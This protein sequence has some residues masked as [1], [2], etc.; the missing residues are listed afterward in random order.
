MAD[1]KSQPEPSMEEI[2]ASIRRI[3]SEEEQPEAQVAKTAT[4]APAAAPVQ[5][6]APKPAPAAA[7]AP[8]PEPADDEV[9]DLTD[10]VAEDGTVVNLHAEG[11]ATRRAKPEPAPQPSAQA[12]D[13]ELRDVGQNGGDEPPRLVPQ[14]PHERRPSGDLISAAAAA[15]AT[16]SF[17]ALAGAVDREGASDPLS[18]G[19]RSLEDIVKE[20]LRPMLRDWLDANLPALVERLVRREIE[21]LSHRAQE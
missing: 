12:E 14:E 8:D 6:A 10:K 15:A 20:I 2:L 21:R 4:A 13:I 3:I 5:Q 18:V 17:A 9:L 19:G 11:N 7:R 1:A 16:A